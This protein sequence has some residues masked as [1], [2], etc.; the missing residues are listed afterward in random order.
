MSINFISEPSKTGTQLKK[1]EEA[2]L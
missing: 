2:T 1:G